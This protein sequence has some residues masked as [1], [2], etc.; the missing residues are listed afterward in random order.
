MRKS[1]HHQALYAGVCLR[2]GFPIGHRCGE[3]HQS[4]IRA[5]RFEAVQNC[6]DLDVEVVG[7]AFAALLEPVI[8]QLLG[9]ALLDDRPVAFKWRPAGLGL[10]VYGH[11]LDVEHFPAAHGQAD[12]GAM[13]S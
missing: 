13:N 6:H 11:R 5:A 9:E 3:A 7:H 2:Q 10:Q 1:F 8:D 4:A 12:F